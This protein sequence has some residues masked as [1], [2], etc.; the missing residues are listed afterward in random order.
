MHPNVCGD[1][2]ACGTLSRSHVH[3]GQSRTVVRT[4][5]V[6][7]GQVGAKGSAVSDTN[8][9]D[10]LSV[11]GLLEFLSE[12]DSTRNPPVYDIS[13]ERI[14]E[15]ADADLPQVP[16]VTLDSTGAAWLSVDYL[17]LPLPPQPPKHAAQALP[18]RFTAHV[19]PE[20][21]SGEALVEAEL[22]KVAS[23]QGVP[24]EHATVPAA[25]VAELHAASTAASQWVAGA[26]QNWSN[27][28]R[29]AEQA[30]TLYRDLF[31][32]QARLVADRDSVEFVWGFGKLRWST[33]DGVHVNAPLLAVPVE[34]E[35]DNKTQTLHVR[36]DGD[37][38]VQVEYLASL[39]LHD[40]P[41][42]LASRDS[43]LATGLDPWG[44]EARDVLRKLV[45]Q[46]HLEGVVAGEGAARPNAPVLTLG[47]VLYVRRR[48][49]NYQKFLADLSELYR[50]GAEIPLPL[51]GVVLDAPTTSTGG[52]ANPPP[53][54]PLLL[55]LPAN[56]EQ[57][58]ILRL[59]Q[60][61]SGVV[62]QGPPGTGKT[63]T[64]ANLISHYVAY[65][66]RVLVLAEKERALREVSGKVP[67]GIRDL[68]VSVLGADEESRRRLG[69]AI[70]VIQT[71]VTSLDREATDAEILRLTAQLNELDRSIAATTTDMLRS[72]ELETRTLNGQWPCEAPVSPQRAAEWVRT[73][74][75]QLRGI[76]DWLSATT[77]C[78]IDAA[79]LAELIQ[80]VTDI[81][82]DR[83]AKALEALTP[84]D[85]LP[86]PADLAAW[87]TAVDAAQEQLAAVADRVQDWSALDA[88]DAHTLSALRD[89][90]AALAGVLQ[91]RQSG[92]L[93]AVATQLRDPLLAPEWQHCVTEINNARERVITLRGPLAGHDVVL[94]GTL[95]DAFIA[96]ID[97]AADALASSGR[98]GLFAR[99][100]K[101]ALEQCRIDGG[102]ATTPQ[103]VTLIQAAIGAARARRAL[104]TRWGNQVVAAG[105]PALSSA[106]PEVE[107]REPLELLRSCVWLD[108]GWAELRR[109]LA[110]LH[111]EIAPNPT[112]QEAV[113]VLAALNALPARVAQRQAQSRI[114][115]LAA[116]LA[117][118]AQ[119][120]EASGLWPLLS[121]AVRGG[122]TQR[123]AELRDE[124]AA[125]T[126]LRPQA[127]RLRE[128]R[129]RLAAAAPIWAQQLMSSPAAAGDPTTLT[130]AWQWRQLD[131]WVSQVLQTVEPG[132]LQRRLHDLVEQRRR[133]VSD[134]VTQRA[135]RRLADNLGDRERRGLNTYL[136]AVT[137]YGK[138]GGK[139]EARRAAE[140][141]RA[142]DECKNAVPVWVMT[143]ARALTSFQPEEVPPFDV[144]IL[145]EASQAGY[146]ALPL[147]SLAKQVIVVGDDKQ[148][149]PE[150][151]GLDR[152]RV[153]EIMEDHLRGVRGY[154]TLFDPDNSL[155]DIARQRFTKSVMLVEHFRC[156]PDIIRFSNTRFYNDEIQPL[157]DR[158]PQ[159]DWEPLG[160][161]RVLDG[162]R[163]GD[164]NRPEAEAV[165]ELL[166]RL[167]ADPRY[168]GMS[169]GV[170]T[171]LAGGQAQLIDTMLLDRLTP[172]RY[173]ARD[174]Q[175]GDAAAFQGAERDVMVVS[176]VVAPDPQNPTRGPAA[177][178][179]EA[180]YRRLNVAA[181]RAQQQMWVVYSV[182]PERFHP[183]D[184]RGELIRH[185]RDPH[186]VDSGGADTLK[187]CDSDFER[188]VAT[189]I[190]ERG[191]RWLFAQYAVGSES[192]NY[193]IDLVV[194]GP[195]GRLAIECDGERW[196]GP[197]R[198]H[199][200]HTRQQVLERAGW[201]FERIR[202][203]AFYR[204]E[205]KALQPL[206]ARLA[207]LGINPGDDQSERSTRGQVFEVTAGQWRTADGEALAPAAVVRRAPTQAPSTHA[208]LAD[209]PVPAVAPVVSD[210]P[211]V[212]PTGQPQYVRPVVIPGQPRVAPSAPGRAGSARDAILLAAYR[213][214]ARSGRDSFTANEVLEDMLTA[215]TNYAENTIKTM[216][217]SHM[218]GD[219]SLDRIDRG[220]YRVSSRVVGSALGRANATAA[221]A[222][223]VVTPERDSATAADDLAFDG[224]CRGCGK[225]GLIA[226]TYCRRCRG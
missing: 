178:T 151:V 198:W 50:D 116:T 57:L 72:R 20:V 142:M 69:Q 148:T 77:A 91:Q 30:K 125:L 183:N 51:Q 145:D 15:L 197:D 34:V 180:D 58:Q 38:E 32:Q 9:Q 44:E 68:T 11:V 207:E 21:T 214:M 199:A 223:P 82:A 129:D 202:G 135:W 196:H 186:A 84:L 163:S 62:V 55:P 17:D 100:A 39:K 161:V 182:E 19:E 56:E 159:L 36:P 28:Y 122:A 93:A 156:L 191:F 218:V 47:W 134:L 71:R 139:Y 200:D 216:I 53:A 67:A 220:V 155:Y 33:A 140:I 212:A 41:G 111:I 66:K 172:E 154:R 144:L 102:P 98:L 185:C 222:A 127:Q 16:G 48:R 187:R 115:A 105:G 119:Q 52:S 132:V 123:Y 88:T 31:T 210:T 18:A 138:T 26:W 5:G 107:V 65:G 131:V 124:V 1:P 112:V 130:R 126:A 211:T 152:A 54:D 221:P 92:W 173:R 137:R 109:D 96:G 43:L 162:Y 3:A 195:S 177:A 27:A 136:Q 149:S 78:P 103:H 24:V 104:V 128:L 95:D 192:R 61:P 224:R 63:H 90:A 64:I 189:H 206:W 213:V 166:A 169:F 194:A 158:A 193:R 83:A 75:Q 35:L 160:A 80:L 208:P 118:G 133:V 99:A 147:L 40:R 201:T 108:A 225:E 37:V 42:L 181:S 12:L 226:N 205:A 29:A 167:D 141:R 190:L 7:G 215:G 174:L 106:A 23:L 4:A 175:V 49:P 60:A 165:V 204:D 113:D 74:E 87:H 13:T 89:R 120:P 101:A 114:A 22:R 219:G 217:S 153:F 146:Q 157:R 179:R 168:D 110:T 176:L 73:H 97:K 6:A 8:G 59:A 203:S 25:R 46:L 2:P 209:G 164:V 45:R 150:N 86:T 10:E 188:R 70:T 14:Y 121:D 143:S 76:P 117:A 79:D 171:L 85:Q 184:M 94:P 170:V 81:G